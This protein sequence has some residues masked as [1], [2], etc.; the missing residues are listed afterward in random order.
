MDGKSDWDRTKERMRTL[1][2]EPASRKRTLERSELVR[3]VG[4]IRF[5]PGSSA[6]A[7]MLAEIAREEDERAGL[8]GRPRRMRARRAAE[9]LLRDLVAERRG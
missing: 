7:A 2:R 3:L 8:A 1:L 9:R 6:L 4:P 5:E